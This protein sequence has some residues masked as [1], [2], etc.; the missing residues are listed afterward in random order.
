[1]L[2]EELLTSY[3]A[4]AVERLNR[5]LAE[6]QKARDLIQDFLR[7]AGRS[8]RPTG[9]LLAIDQVPQQVPNGGDLSRAK[10]RVDYVVGE[11]I[12]K[13][14]VR[15]KCVLL[16]CLEIKPISHRCPSLPSTIACR[17]I[18]FPPTGDISR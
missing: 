10:D 14:A 11:W 8:V 18:G 15:L 17:F 5:G 12:A 16:Q 2:R 13:L 3:D 6:L 9:E 7:Q 4:S 1:M